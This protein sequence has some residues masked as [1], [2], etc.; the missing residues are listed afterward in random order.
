MSQMRNGTSERSVTSPKKYVKGGTPE[1][2]L[3]PK[4]PL[5]ENIK[6]GAR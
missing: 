4:N 6:T 3:S 5:G 2:K 1:V